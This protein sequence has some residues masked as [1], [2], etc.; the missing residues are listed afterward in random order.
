MPITVLDLAKHRG[1]QGDPHGGFSLEEIEKTGLPFWCGCAC[2]ANLGPHNA[3]P[4]KSGFSACSDCIG[5]SGFETVEEAFASIFGA[6]KED[7]YEDLCQCAECN[8]PD[9]R[10]D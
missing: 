4:S 1:A 8:L 2:S 10:L 9:N 5:T 3:Y 6:E 7:E